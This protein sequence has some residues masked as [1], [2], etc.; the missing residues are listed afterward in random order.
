MNLEHFTPLPPSSECRWVVDYDVVVLSVPI[1]LIFH[2]YSG[3]QRQAPPIIPACPP[4][5][6]CSTLDDICRLWGDLAK[7]KMPFGGTNIPAAYGHML[8]LHLS[9][10]PS[11]HC[12]LNQIPEPPPNPTTTLQLLRKP[13]STS[14]I[15]IKQAPFALPHAARATALTRIAPSISRLSSADLFFLESSSRAARLISMQISVKMS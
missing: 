14:V 12:I 5:S 11:F 3:K 15:T 9:H 4:P 7:V 10:E 2:L 8:T 13:Q 6:F 1:C